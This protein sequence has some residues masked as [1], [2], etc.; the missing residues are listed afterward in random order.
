[1][2]SE[3][4]LVEYAR[5]WANPP[6]GDLPKL[7]EHAAVREVLARMDRAAAAIERVREELR[8]ERE[9]NRGNNPALGVVSAIER[10]LDGT[11]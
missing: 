2:S 5:W 7:P 3:D 11:P 8:A 6:K 10:A 1:M 9:I 4:D